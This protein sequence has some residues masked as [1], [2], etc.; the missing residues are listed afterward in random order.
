MNPYGH[1][2][3]G[4]R[5]TRAYQSWSDM[6]TRVFNPNCKEHHLY[7]DRLID[8]RW[9]SF[10]NFYADMGDRPEGLTLQRIDNAKGYGPEN[11][12]WG[13]RKE[14]ARNKIQKNGNKTKLTTDIVQKIMKDTDSLVKIGKKYGVGQTAIFN[15]KHG[16][17]WKEVANV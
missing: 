5:H 8:T 6:K 12:K 2:T 9:L 4:K 11:C 13:T 17:S 3:H 7:K 16:I 1:V 10:E 14:Q 15:I